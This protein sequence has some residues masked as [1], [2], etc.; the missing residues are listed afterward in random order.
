MREDSTATK[1][2]KDVGP[3]LF[4]TGLRK[5]EDL[6]MARQKIT[7]HVLKVGAIKKKPT[8]SAGKS[9]PHQKTR[10]RENLGEK[11]DNTEIDAGAICGRVGMMPHGGTLLE[12]ATKS[13]KEKTEAAGGG[14]GRTHRGGRNTRRS[15]LGKVFPLTAL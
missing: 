4:D 8:F 11:K 7:R 13:S 12:A 1:R 14:L 9:T 10:H 3:S 5:G 6:H 15:E 2:M